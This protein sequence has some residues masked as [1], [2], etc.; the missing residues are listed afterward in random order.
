MTTPPSASSSTPEDWV[1]LARI[2]KPQGRK[3]EVFAEIL[4]DFPN[5]FAER[6]SLTLLSS[7]ETP[8]AKA[9]QPRPA[10]L[11]HHWL[12]KGAIVL[13]FDGINSITE[14][15][16]LTGLI[17]AVPREQRATL[18]PDEIYI[19]DL[20]GCQLIDCATTPP[21]TLG[22]IEEVDRTAGPVALLIV[23]PTES[24]RPIETAHPNQNVESNLISSQTSD[25]ILIPFAKA[26][27][28]NIDL[29]A[30]IIEMNLPEGLAE[31]N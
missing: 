2:R 7:P 9:I 1:W 24:V 6:R 11:I 20:I 18:A 13:H 12:H 30:R 19:G 26:Y 15:E 16:S 27:I 17:V 14:A 5:L 4:T 8:A 23:R 25:E 21:R 29:T 10:T 31:L 28:K 3:G 22:L